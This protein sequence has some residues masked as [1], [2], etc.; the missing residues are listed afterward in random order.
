MPTISFSSVHQALFSGKFWEIHPVGGGQWQTW[1]NKGSLLGIL[2]FKL[3][4]RAREISP[5]AGSHT[6][7]TQSSRETLWQP[8]LQVS[9]LRHKELLYYSLTYLSHLIDGLYIEPRNSFWDLISV[10]TEIRQERTLLELL[11]TQK[12]AVSSFTWVVKDD[13]APEKHW[14]CKHA[15]AVKPAPILCSQ[16]NEN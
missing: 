2:A 1:P 3:G 15:R 13:M 5:P 16:I 7:L 8:L 12:N 4:G 11:K 6:F 10:H 9:I 14:R